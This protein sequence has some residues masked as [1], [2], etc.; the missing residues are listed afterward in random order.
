MTLHDLSA[1]L[2]QSHVREWA[3]ALV[4]WLLGLF[5][6][7]ASRRIVW[8]RLARLA[9]RT[10]KKWDDLLLA[11]LVG[12]SRLLSVVLSLAF[13][14]QLAPP[15][16][17]DS[18]ALSYGVKIA[19]VICGAWVADRVARVALRAGSNTIN[20]K[21]SSRILL[22][23]ILRAF[24][25]V[26]G[27]LVVLDTVGVSITPV[28]ASLGVGSVAVALALQDTLSNFFSGIYILIDEPIRPGDFIQIEGGVEG[29]VA[30]IGWRSTH[31]R[32][33]SNNT[34]VIPNSKL[35]SSSLTNFDLPEQETAVLM[36]VGVSYD[37]DLDQVER[38]VKEVS[39]E[40]LARVPGAVSGFEPF[41]RYH[42]F[43]DSSINF[44]VILRASRIT[45]QYLLKHE[46][47]KAL[48][49]RFARERITIPYPQRVVHLQRDGEGI[50]A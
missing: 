13:A 3:I 16:L 23:T 31:V 39:R 47:V 15:E 25:L 43:G 4:V 46:F 27:S 19:L 5:V 50:K 1:W 32:L 12:P 18:K 29:T 48:H 20:L 33:L 40:V 9:A 14:A 17:R 34:V 45:D 6:L 21:E 36:Q 8:A 30:K 38:V 28:L 41:I 7:L 35:A 42:T 11:D 22:S 10:Q 26:I 49:A 44:T 24:V 2:T 37:S